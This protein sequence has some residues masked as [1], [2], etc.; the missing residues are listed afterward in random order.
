MRYTAKS[1]TLFVQ[2]SVAMGVPW[3][4]V[5]DKPKITR[6]LPSAHRLYEHFPATENCAQPSRLLHR[7]SFVLNKFVYSIALCWSVVRRPHCFIMMMKLG[8]LFYA[9]QLHCGSHWCKIHSKTF[10]RANA[11]PTVDCV[12][13]WLGTIG[14]VWKVAGR[15][16][17]GLL[18]EAEGRHRPAEGAM[19]NGRH[20]RHRQRQKYILIASKSFPCR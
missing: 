17:N 1:A 20:R 5:N 3:P 12:Q 7:C 13:H 2:T 11:K 6:L 8:K 15:R 4:P 10:A 14:S 19:W 9:P 18:C 16:F